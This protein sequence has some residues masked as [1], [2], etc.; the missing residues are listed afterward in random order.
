MVGIYR[1]YHKESGRNYVGKSV[2]IRKRAQAH[3]A[4]KDTGCYISKSIRKYGK[5]AFALEVLELCSEDNLEIREAHWIAALDC[6]APHGYNLTPGDSH[7]RHTVETRRKI[8]KA[9]QGQQKSE[10]HR[11]NLSKA[12]KGKRLSAEQCQKMSEMFSGKG[13][14]FYG[15]KHTVETRQK[16]AQHN[17][18]RV[19]SEETRR[20]LSMSR[21]GKKRPAETRRKISEAKLGEKNP[22]YGKEH[23]A[24]TRQKMSNALK[25]RTLSEEHRKKIRL[26][27]QERHRNKSQLLLFENLYPKK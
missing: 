23:T 13:N 2:N 3:F 18:K 21:K 4:P 15:K 14:P 9:H 6:M 25:G 17:K 5:D 27:H 20:K 1:I 7:S 10:E 22:F 8:S 19:I 11:L 16:I 12:Q 24:E 26:A